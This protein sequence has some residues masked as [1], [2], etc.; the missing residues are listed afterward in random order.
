MKKDQILHILN[1]NFRKICDALYP[2]E[3]IGGLITDD[4]VSRSAYMRRVRIAKEWAREKGL[5]ID[6]EN[7]RY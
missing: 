4:H 7:C 6:W 1:E 2:G 5:L 3:V